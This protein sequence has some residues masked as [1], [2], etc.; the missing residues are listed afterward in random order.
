MLGTLPPAHQKSRKS[1]RRQHRSSLD[2][3]AFRS[4]TGLDATASAVGEMIYNLCKAIGG[5]ITK[6]IA[7][8]V[9]LR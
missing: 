9:F 3:R 7:E 5:R 1:I 4:I 6:E 2:V 8:C